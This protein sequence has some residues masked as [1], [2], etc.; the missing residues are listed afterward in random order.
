MIAPVAHVGSGVFEPL[1]L[2]PPFAALAAYAVRTR[3]LSRQ[4][5]P[6][7]LWRALCFG[8]GIA[9]IVAA[10]VSP[11]AHIGGELIL[12]HMAQHVLMADLAA[13]LMVLGLTGPLMQ[14]LLATPVVRRLRVLAHPVVAFAL[15]AIDLYV[16]HLPVLYQAALSSEVVHVLQHGSFVFFGF[17]M[18]LALLGPL[19]QP[20]W[21]GNGARLLYIVGVR[22]T[23]ALLGNVFVWSESV[24][25]P[26]YRPGQAS[27]DL[28]PLQDQGVAGTIMM[29]ESSIVTVLLL[30]WLF[31][32]AA[33]E[34]EEKQTLLELA[35]ARGVEL[36]ERR[37]ARAVAAGRGD[38]LRRR[39]ER[40]ATG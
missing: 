9:L 2:L 26:D 3:T 34:S 40:A 14:P 31:V 17:T 32:K 4:G 5:R 35:S 1:Q 24:F 16:W 13:L 28:S 21:F 37:A 29:V 33:R 11:V 20:E 19:P 38:E 8:G 23:G 6:V 36:S 39:L 30:G 7:P 25:Y 22:L 18:W 12:A 15:W 27:W 10:L